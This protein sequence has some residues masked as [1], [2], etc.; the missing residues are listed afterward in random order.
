M[1]TLIKGSV[2]HLVDEVDMRS[3]R[4]YAKHPTTGI[5]L[6]EL[7]VRSSRYQGDAQQPQTSNGHGRVS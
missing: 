3:I 6:R 7:S 1:I 2:L 4:A 5:F